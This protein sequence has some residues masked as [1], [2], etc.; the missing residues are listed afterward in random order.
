MIVETKMGEIKASEMVFQMDYA[1]CRMYCYV[2]M[3]KDGELVKI[4]IPANEI[5]GI[6]NDDDP[7]EVVLNTFNMIGGK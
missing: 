3:K 4:K 2:F 7:G 1:E 6:K 5:Y